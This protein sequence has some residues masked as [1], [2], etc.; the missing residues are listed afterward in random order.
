MSGAEEGISERDLRVEYLAGEEDAEP[1]RE[2][3]VAEDDF[4]VLLVGRDGGVKHRYPEPT[5]PDELFGR[6]DE[7]PMRQR[8][9]REMQEMQEM[10]EMREMREARGGEG[11]SIRE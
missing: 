5:G 1:R 11:P 2:R 3:G 9:V 7:M 10:R 4:V 8:E 6:I